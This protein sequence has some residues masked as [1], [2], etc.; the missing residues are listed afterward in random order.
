MDETGYD[1]CKTE[2]EWEK[3]GGEVGRKIVLLFTVT[4]VLKE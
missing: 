2:K 3:G 4:T 1:V